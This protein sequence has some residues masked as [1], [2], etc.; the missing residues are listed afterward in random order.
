V[1]GARERVAFRVVSDPVFF[2]VSDLDVPVSDLE[3]SLRLYAGATGFPVMKRGEGFAVV[4]AGGVRLRLVHTRSPEHRTSLR[5]STSD[6]AGAIEVFARAGA[7]RLYA[8]MK[9]PQ[10]ELVAAV[11]DPDGHTV[12]LWRDL[13]E[14]EYDFEPALPKE[15]TWEKPAEELLQALLKRVPA[16]FRALARY[17][18]TKEA[19]SLAEKTRRVGREEVIRGF[20]LASPRVTRSRN[21]KPLVELG[22]DA[23]KYQADWD[24]P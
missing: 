9:T 23:D 6:V 4:D 13:T 15:L 1:R 2:G 12:Y 3:R 17:R 14:D 19:E 5:L 8:P 22:I 16:L 11:R 7:T 21:R 10:Q 20:I 24:A 18:V